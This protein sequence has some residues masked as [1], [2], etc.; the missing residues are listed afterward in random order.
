MRCGLVGSRL[1]GSSF[2]DESWL[3]RCLSLAALLTCWLV[4]AST[5]AYDRN[6]TKWVPL[7]DRLANYSA[8]AIERW[9]QVGGPALEWRVSAVDGRV[10]VALSRELTIPGDP[11]PMFPVQVDGYELT[12]Y[13][14]YTQTDDGWLISFRRGEWGGAL[15]WISK[16][17]RQ[18]QLLGPLQVH[19]F[20]RDGDRFLAIEGLTHL[21]MTR[22]SLIEIYRE[23]GVP[24]WRYRTV[25][26]MP[27]TP[28]AL[29]RLDDGTLWIALFGAIVSFD[30][31]GQRKPVVNLPSGARFPTSIAVTEDRKWVYV[32]GRFWVTEVDVITRESRILVPPE[33]LD[34]LESQST[35]KHLE[36]VTG[37][38][39]AFTPPAPDPDLR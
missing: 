14:T 9:I 12:K 24:E 22:G 37:T 39:P 34:Q 6:L 33:L 23:G 13:D 29:T 5:L 20:L 8:E 16:D 17:G 2:P 26:T 38:E 7:P 31:N 25:K 11:K 15:Y 19:Q 1:L 4:P 3:S 36:W 27:S 35:V 10:Q 21:A 30:V 32:G 18:H 28:Y